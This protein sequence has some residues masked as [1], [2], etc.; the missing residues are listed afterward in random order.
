MTTPLS[1]SPRLL[2]V[3]PVLVVALAGCGGGSSGPAATVPGGASPSASSTASA[4]GQRQAP[5]VS[6]QAAEVTGDTLQVRTA[7]GQTAVRFS[8][9]T[10]ITEQRTA[11][12]SAVTVGS[13][14]VA[15][16]RPDAAGTGVEAQTVAVTPA[17]GGTCE[18]GAFG[19]GAGGGGFR[20]GTGRPSFSPGQGGTGQ[21]GMGQGGAPATPM[22]SA[23][24]TVTAVTPTAIT[25]SGRVR[26]FARGAGSPGTSPSASPAAAPVTVTV[27]AST[28]Y[29]ATVVVTSSALTVGQCVVALG[30]P[31]DIGTVT[32]RSITIRPADAN[33]CTTGFGGAGGFGGFG[34]G[35]RAAGSASP[36]G[37]PGA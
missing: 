24:G 20:G 2:V 17:S 18:D 19:R 23:V 6:G 37:T 4:T 21:G 26:T 31:D 16:G 34:G 28:R 5:G 7:D 15:T 13:C 22:S 29:T 14:V 36:A 25:L 35:R 9:S 33:G 8:A 12:L 30:Q 27:A 10:R 11:A 3:A 32:A 1:R